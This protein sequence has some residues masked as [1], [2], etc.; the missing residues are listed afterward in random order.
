MKKVLVTIMALIYLTASVGATVHMH[1]CMNKLVALGLNKKNTGNKA[2]PYCGMGKSPKDKHC[3]KE[4]KGCCK[5]EQK[6]VKLENDQK[7]TESAIHLAQVFAEAITPAFSIYSFEYI[8]SLTEEYPLTNAP[9]RTQN[10][11]L[12]VLNSVFR[13]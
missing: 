3:S 13:I 11:A 4:S 6:Q 10:V 5:D 12:F 8:S 7:L 1:Y 9:P 2:C